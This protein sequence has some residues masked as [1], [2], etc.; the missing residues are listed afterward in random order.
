MIKFCLFKGDI[1]ACD[2][3]TIQLYNLVPVYTCSEEDYAA[4]GYAYHIVNGQVILGSSEAQIL[5]ELRSRRESECFSYVNRGALWYNTLTSEQQLELD[6][7]YKAWLN[8][9]Q[10]YLET[11]PTNIETIIPQK[12]SWLI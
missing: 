10:V 7:W 4:A 9:P 5:E 8:V 2:E 11:K 1:V 6:T 3:N 12:P